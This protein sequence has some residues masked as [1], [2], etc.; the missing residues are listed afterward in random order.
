ML[1]EVAIMQR[2]W[3]N[4]AVSERFIVPLGAIQKKL[5]WFVADQLQSAGRGCLTSVSLW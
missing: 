2:I 4:I 1:R 3:A 5:I